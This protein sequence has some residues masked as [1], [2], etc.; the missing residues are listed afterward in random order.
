MF[1]SYSESV[2]NGFLRWSRSQT[3]KNINDNDQP[4]ESTPVS[5]AHPLSD[6]DASKGLTGGKRMTVHRRASSPSR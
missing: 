4:G 6:P 1:I 3:Q 2:T 5:L